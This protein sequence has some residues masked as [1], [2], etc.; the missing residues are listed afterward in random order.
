MMGWVNVS[1]SSAEVNAQLKQP[2]KNSQEILAISGRLVKCNEAFKLCDV[3]QLSKSNEFFPVIAFVG[4]PQVAECHAYFKDLVRFVQGTGREVIVDQQVAGATGMTPKTARHISK[5]ANLIIIFGG[6]GTFLRMVHELYGTSAA[7]VGVQ[8]FGTLGF[9]TEHSHKKLKFHL[10]HFFTGKYK[11]NERSLIEVLVIRRGQEVARLQGLN[12]AVVSCPGIARMIS[13]DLSMDGQRMA[14]YSADGM[15]VATP[16]GSTAYSLSAG[17]P[18]VYPSM[19]SFVITP[20]SPHMLTHRPIVIPNNRVITTRIGQ[21][22]LLL[23]VDGQRTVHLRPGDDVVLQK[24]SWLLRVAY[25]KDRNYFAV[26][27]EKLQWGERLTKKSR[28]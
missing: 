27:R 20:I 24:A 17:G 16:T 15:I 19:H 18:I 13:L 8:L 28:K 11:L 25:E 14:R 7:V 3:I 26:L 10:K 22:H 2:K 1:R 4:K 9:L 12:E 21:E 23:T 5:H 6:D